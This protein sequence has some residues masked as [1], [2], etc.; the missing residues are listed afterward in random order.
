MVKVFVGRWYV[1]DF[2]FGS[3]LM[4]KVADDDGVVGKVSGDVASGDVVLTEVVGLR[5]VQ[6]PQMGPGG[7]SM[8]PGVAG[9][10][11]FPTGD[12]FDKKMY[13]ISMAHVRWYVELDEAEVEKMR[14]RYGDG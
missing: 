3:R 8:Q 7:V 4:G 2:G 14:R 13:Y 5:D 9:V 11:L 1:F 10:P 12:P 6:T